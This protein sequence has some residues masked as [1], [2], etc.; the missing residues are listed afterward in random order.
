M[1]QFSYARATGLDE[2]IAAGA[3]PETAFLAGGT[4]L[5]NWLR[6]GIAAPARIVDITR[7]DGLDRIEA[8]PQGGLRIG[9][10]A[11]LNDAAQ[12]EVVMRD[13]PVLS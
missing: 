3:E 6:L 13:Y 8:L 11:R 2:A 12:H 5:L 4:E 1:R 10:L 7:L 9:A